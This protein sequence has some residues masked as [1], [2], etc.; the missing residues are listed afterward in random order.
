MFKFSH[1][2]SGQMCHRSDLRNCR[3]YQS[4][5]CARLLN[6]CQRVQAGVKVSKIV[7]NSNKSL[8]IVTQFFESPNCVCRPKLIVAIIFVKNVNPDPSPR[9][10]WG[11][12]I[13]HHFLTFGF[14]K[15]Q[16]VQLKIKTFLTSQNLTNDRTLSA[17]CSEVQKYGV[18]EIYLGTL[19]P[20]TDPP[21]FWPILTKFFKNCN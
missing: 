18:L 17:V 10:L 21:N 19:S 20:Q 13:F 14:T 15:F 5:F 4:A 9:K 8:L 6:M 3:R 12:T 11:V 7:S 16:Q 2:F 1:F